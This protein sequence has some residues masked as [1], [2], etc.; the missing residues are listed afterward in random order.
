[1]ISSECRSLL[2]VVHSAPRTVHAACCSK[3]QDLELLKAFY[4]AQDLPMEVSAANGL[5]KP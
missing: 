4:Y 3:S 5:T 1:M 2:E